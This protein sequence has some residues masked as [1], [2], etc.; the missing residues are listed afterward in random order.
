MTVNDGTSKRRSS[1][2]PARR[3][4]RLR[5]DGASSFISQPDMSVITSSDSTDRAFS[6]TMCCR[7]DDVTGR[8]RGRP[9]AC[10]GDSIRGRCLRAR[11]G[12]S[13]CTEWVEHVAGS[14]DGYGRLIQFACTMARRRADH[15]G[16]DVAHSAHPTATPAHI[17]LF[18]SLCRRSTSS[19]AIAA[20]LGALDD[21]IES[22]RRAVAK[23]GHSLDA[24]LHAMGTSARG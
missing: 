19:E 10:T 2:T 9:S 4:P 5:S 13:E 22:N 23:S 14:Y 20:T 21:K 18:R 17:R 1:A 8:R 6:T 3:A 15:E 7:F 16:H 11:L 12:S 24:R